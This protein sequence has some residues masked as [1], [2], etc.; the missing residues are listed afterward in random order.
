[1]LPVALNS[2][3]FWSPDQP[4]KRSGII[5]VDYLNAIEPGLNGAEFTRRSQA[6]IER[7]RRNAFGEL[8]EA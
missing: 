6:V 8:C 4:Y 7:A 1:V 2:G 3:H 5:T